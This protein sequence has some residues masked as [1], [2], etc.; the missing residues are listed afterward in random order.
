LSLVTNTR[1]HPALSLGASPRGSLAL[2]HSAQARAALQGRDYVIPDDVQYL[3]P[4][5]LTHRLI[6]R[7]EAGLRGQTAVRI[8]QEIL[9]ST[10]LKLEGAEG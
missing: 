5:T 10:P 3:V 8:V 4:A 1:D 2:Y 9:E 6:L 7:P